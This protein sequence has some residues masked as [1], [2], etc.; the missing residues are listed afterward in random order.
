[1]LLSASFNQ[2]PRLRLAASG[3]AV[4]LGSV[5]RNIDGGGGSAVRDG[6]RGS[7]LGA[8][9]LVCRKVEADEQDEVAAQD[10]A[11]RESSKLLTGALAR[12]GD[13]GP[14]GRGEVGVRRKVDEA[15]GTR[16]IRAPGMLLGSGNT[17][18]GQ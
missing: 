16:Q 8:S 2:R 1:M 7:A 13:M 10:T 3:G 11:A 15:W 9:L 6:R 18:Q 14:V 5:G 17:D 4:L 12:V